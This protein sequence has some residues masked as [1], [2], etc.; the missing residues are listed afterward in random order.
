M[1]TF[2]FILILVVAILVSAIIGQFTHR[3]SLP[4]IQIGTGLA[5]AVLYLSPIDP[6]LD[7]DFFLLLFIAPLLFHDAK[8][9]D[10]TALWSNRYIILSLAVGLVIAI[11]LGVGLFISWLIPAVPFAV[12]LALGATLGPT[13]AVAVASMSESAE[14]DRDDNALLQGEALLN[15]ASGVVAFQFAVVYATTGGFSAGEAITSFSTL[16]VGGIAVGAV[17]AL[18]LHAVETRIR[19]SGMESTTF[20]ILYDI[21]CPFAIYLAAEEVFGFSGVLAVV[22]AGIILGSY[23]DQRIGP[24]ISQLN[25]KSQSVWDLLS[26]LINGIVFVMLGFQL[27]RAMQVVWG[28]LEVSHL[29]LIGWVLGITAIIVLVRFLWLLATNYRAG[30]GANRTKVKW[31]QRVLSAL[32]TTCGGPKGA[33]TLAIVF[34]LP[35]VVADGSAFP[36]RDLIIFL[37]S[38]VIVCT[39]VLANI[40]LPLLAPATEETNEQ[41]EMQFAQRRIAV[42]QKVIARLNAQ[43]EDNNAAAIQ[44]VVVSYLNRI[45]RIRTQNDITDPRLRDEGTNARLWVLQFQNDYVN[46]LMDEDKVDL[47]L[48]YAFLKK[49][50]RM[51]NVARHSH[52]SFRRAIT[53][54]AKRGLRSVHMAIG[55]IRKSVKPAGLEDKIAMTNLQIEVEEATIKQ[56]EGMLDGKLFSSTTVASVLAA[57]HGTLA[58]LRQGIPSITQQIASYNED[59]NDMQAVGLKLELETI[60]QEYEKGRLTRQQARSMREDVYLMQMDLEGFI[61]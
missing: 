18:V 39:L 57:H 12:A 54:I 59:F 29:Q 1:A 6:T 36:Q 32:I 8:N 53:R 11:T 45:S 46:T 17:M 48:G 26:Y 35:Y 49:L 2:E 3:V 56:L 43:I 40:A 9:A 42:L 14:L 24:S 50:D 28:N 5:C 10:K 41:S 23:H 7:P 61:A 60:Q 13:D 4:L 47:V 31:K 27:P 21:L 55:V 15:D 37:A 51:E 33:V 20:Y 38:G 44:S 34:S 58:R 25:I 30:R 19:N 22:T 16:F 52:G